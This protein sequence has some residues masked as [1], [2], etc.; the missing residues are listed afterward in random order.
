MRG[1]PG[2]NCRYF[3]KVGEDGDGKNG[4]FKK[5]SRRLWEALKVSE[6]TGLVLVTGR[7]PREGMRPP[8]GRGHQ[9]Q[10]PLPQL[11]VLTLIHSRI[12]F[13]FSPPRN[14]SPL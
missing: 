10:C 6:A 7:S 8:L 11:T 1:S 9:F 3:R 12:S 14:G 2:L 4:Y 5:H 13:S